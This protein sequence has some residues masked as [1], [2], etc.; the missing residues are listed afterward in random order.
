VEIPI[1]IKKPVSIFE[2]KLTGFRIIYFAFWYSRAWKKSQ[3][4]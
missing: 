1:F 4:L 3:I 2:E